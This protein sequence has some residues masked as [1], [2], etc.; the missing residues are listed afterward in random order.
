MR[1]QSTDET[2]VTGGSRYAPLVVVLL[3]AILVSNFFRGSEEHRDAVAT[4]DVPQRKVLIAVKTL[5]AGKPI[6]R[7]SLAEALRPTAT[8]PPETIDDFAKVEGKVPVG[9]IPAGYPLAPELLSERKAV[10]PAVTPESLAAQAE[11]AL[12]KVRGNTVALAINF[13]APPPRKGARVA[14]SLQGPR[15][16]PALVAEEAWVDTV[17][18]NT[19]QVRVPP[20]TALFLEEVKS[21]GTFS[22]FEIGAEGPSPFQGTAINDVAT[23]R[24]RLQ[25]IDEKIAKSAE[26]MVRRASEGTLTASSFSSFAWSQD[27]RTKY[28]IDASGKIYVIERDGKAVPLHEYNLGLESTGSAPQ[29]PAPSSEAA[30]GGPRPPEEV[31]SG[32]EPLMPLVGA[33]K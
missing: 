13:S 22:Y 14:L 30:A 20:A 18:G 32:L 7:E 1:V 12:A 27:R 28:G 3:V 25:T 9:P 4:V 6:L 2:K 26:Q 31:R 17:S 29:L 33:G 10:E 11:E 19:A 23:L 5:E 24:E 21:L 15:G 8:L 16:R